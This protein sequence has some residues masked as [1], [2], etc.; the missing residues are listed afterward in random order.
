MTKKE[1]LKKLARLESM[2]DQLISE[3]SM[4]D[5]LMRQVGFSDGLR[6]A[7]ATA[8]EIHQQGYHFEDDEL[9]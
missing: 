8:L 2:H 1:L 5:D 9:W 4:I 3:L 6:T 7:K